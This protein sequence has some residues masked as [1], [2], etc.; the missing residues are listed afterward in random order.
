VTGQSALLSQAHCRVQQQPTSVNEAIRAAL[1]ASLA[2]SSAVVD[3]L[4]D[5]LSALTAD[6]ALVHG[7]A[8]GVLR[9]ELIFV[10]F[11]DVVSHEGLDVRLLIVLVNPVGLPPD[12]HLAHLSEMAQVITNRERLEA[13]LA[14]D[15]EGQA[16]EVLNGASNS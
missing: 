8:E 6:V 11:A 15:S 7:P 2:N 13:L 14:A 4:I 3:R 10:T 16:R 12:R 5:G 1:P 9:P